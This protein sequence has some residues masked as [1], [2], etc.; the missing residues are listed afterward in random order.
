MKWIT[1]GDIKTWI[2][3]DQRGCAQ[4]LPEL[5]RRLILA[6]ASTVEEIEFP[7]GDSVA[8][9]G[10]DGRLKTPVVS[11]MFPAGA[12][13]WEI[14]TEATPEKKAEEDYIKRTTDPLGFVQVDTS[15][16]F[17]T[18]RPWP[19]R[20]KWQNTKRST[21]T[22]KDVRVVAA[23]G[24]EQWLDLAP[25]VALW[26][27][28]KIKGLSDSIRDL[29]GFW[30]EWSAS[31]DPKMT[32]NIVL[33]GRT[34][35]T[36]RIY[37]W[38]RG[39]AAILEVR[40]DSPDEPYAFLYSSIDTL[41]VQERLQA[42]SRCV[43]VEN[44]QQVRSCATTFQNPLIIVAPA[45]C[46]E[47]AGFALD[48]GHHVFLSADA[49]SID[50]RNNLIELSRPLHDIVEKHLR[51]NGLSEMDA[52]KI[53]RD[54]GRSVPVLRRHL[55]RSSAKTPAWADEKSATTLIPLLFAGAWNER[56]NG[57]H[58]VIE[59]LAGTTHD[60][61]TKALKPFLS[62]EDSPIRHIGTIWM[63]KSPLDAWYLLAPHLTEDHLKLFERAVIS[64]LTKTDPK[65][66]LEP[67]KRWMAGVYGKSS[68]Y[69]EWVHIGLV[70]SLILIAVFGNRSSH[71]AST[72]T[73]ADRVV[74]EVFAHADKWEAWASIKDV[75]SLLAEA[76]PIAFMDAV[77]ETLAKKPKLFEEL[78]SDD[79]TTFG[80]CRHSGLLW[81]LEGIAW[82]PEYF[83]R[84]AT[85]LF[86]LSKVDK[87]GRWNNRAINSL[88]DLFMAGLP[89]TN[90]S[91][92]QRITTWDALVKKD[93]TQVWKFAQDY[94]N[95]GVMGESHQFRWR[96]TGGNRRALEQESNE[97][98][99]EYV[100]GIRPRLTDLACRREN[101]VATTDEFTRLPEDLREKLL[102]DLEAVDIESFTKEER[103][104]LLQ[105]L[106]EALNWVNSY[107][108]EDRR[109]QVPAL[110]SIYNKF[111]P[112]DLIDRHGWLLST[113]WPRRPEGESRDYSKHDA[114]V[115]VA[116]EKAARE[117]L[118]QVPLE[119]VTEFASTIQYQGILGYSLGKAVLNADEDAKVLD[120][121]I[122]KAEKCPVTVRGYAQAQ[123][124]KSGPGWIDLQ[125][126]RIK[127]KGN[128]TPAACALL[129]F[130]R[131]EGTDTW[132][133]VAAQGKE[134]EDAYWQ[135]AGGY[136]RSSK[137]ADTPIAVEKLLDAKRPGVA[138]QVAGDPNVSVPSKTLQRLLQD[139]L[140]L[141][142][143][144]RN[145]V[146]DEFHIGN[147][148]NQLYQHND[149]RIEEMAKLEWPYA[150]LFDEI[151]RYT[152]SPMALHRVLQKDPTFFAQLISF[153][154]KRGDRE[155][156]PDQ[157]GAD[158]EIKEKRARVAH[159][160][161]NSWY[162]LPG[163]QDDGSVNEK[164]LTDWI[165][166]ARKKC[167]DD[168]RVT[169]GDIEIGFLLAHA[170]ADPNG[171]W[172]HIAVRNV[173]EG[174][175]NET[176]D[177]HIQNEVY[178]SRGVVSKGLRDGGEQE[179]GLSDKYRKMS[180]AVKAKWPRT[181]AMLRGMAEWYEHDAKGN[182]IES[183][184]HDL[185][186]N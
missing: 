182:D 122:E 132:S 25:A 97:S 129:Y 66:D 147:V 43:V 183:D 176:I 73:F 87:G 110:W 103:D 185:R 48:K 145:Q 81:A 46:R 39:K 1:A 184:L 125:I 167:A 111:L 108:E 84:A 9:S 104:K 26:L 38:L 47:A 79:G 168:D 34:S 179:R 150:A 156:E 41:P 7:S 186:W 137:E 144:Q 40:G 105:C 160:I 42:L 63:V 164:E 6:T 72:Q 70:E 154:Y 126:E 80:E 115:K 17:V 124:E 68:P 18:P 134:V 178:N 142:T 140:T 135:Q 31:T 60:E 173:I 117:V 23:D 130:G 166:E 20:V 143:K 118:D 51:E 102:T 21:A 4:T 85:T 10:W 92:E 120:A 94:F 175:N 30:E 71:V 100:K 159:D 138:L 11:A 109:K 50:F 44:V 96:D 148:F 28:R 113:P 177:R 83:A 174:L 76:S 101:L 52:R 56:M 107:G 15:F 22:W 128:Y 33:G 86:D 27:G 53:A 158:D 127:A 65:Y 12:S 153:I 36:E 90:A 69:S 114:D 61:Y 77:E 133:A 24:I 141:D 54:F 152:S 57:D 121:L 131:D 146:M 162:L 29:E 16:V 163:I 14:G 58:D 136:S 3:S 165:T 180:D 13:V 139:L 62:M 8:H 123:V 93:A 98:Y 181:G 157:E 32:P 55:F 161:L 78:M 19:G 112:A 172:P 155:P 106:R 88:K 2:T 49:R 170:P 37:A 151:K 95:G 74:K 82:N 116:Q 64:V 89:Q 67:E 99:Q 169:G 171:S 91:P 149:L 59:S 35:D 45:E 75:T 5:I 119:R